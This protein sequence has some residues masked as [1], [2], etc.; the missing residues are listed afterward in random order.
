MVP[1][2]SSR[3]FWLA[4][5]LSAAAAWWP[6]RHTSR[7]PCPPTSPSCSECSAISTPTRCG[8]SSRAGRSH[9]LLDNPHLYISGYPVYQ[10][11][12]F[13][14]VHQTLTLNHDLAARHAELSLAELQAEVDVSVEILRRTIA[15]YK[16]RGKKV[17]V[18]G[19]SY[20]AFL[21]T[22]YLAADGPG[23]ADRYVLIAGRLDMPEEFVDGALSGEFFYFPDAVFP[24]EFPLQPM[25]DREFIRLRIM[26]A[27][28]HDRYTE[29]LA[30]TDLQRVIYVYGAADTVVGRLTA[31]EVV[32][33]EST[34]SRIIAV[35][36]G[37]HL[38]LVI[39]PAVVQQIVDALQ[40]LAGR[41]SAGRRTHTNAP[42]QGVFPPGSSDSFVSSATSVALSNNN[43]YPSGSCNS[44]THM[45][46][47]TCG[48]V[49][50][51]PR[52]RAAR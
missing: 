45:A 32:F 47:P 2:D 13:V 44:V 28:A 1:A 20:G 17:V 22:R 14:Q 4:P 46:F 52:S 26:G 18:V 33:L 9:T 6:S 8:S 31:A 24:R 21:T 10:E 12:Q 15:H 48:S 23:A 7:R 16:A 11:I 41:A 51:S 38:S 35:Q 27:T 29:R 34:G 3:C 39:D 30:G 19:Y 25:T 40:E 42:V 43:R 49:A 50:S 37:S 5:S 36:G